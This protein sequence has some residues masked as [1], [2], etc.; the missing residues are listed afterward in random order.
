MLAVDPV[1]FE[2]VLFNMLDNAAKYAPPVRQ[3]AFK[4]GRRTLTSS[5]KSLTRAAA[6]RRRRL[7]A[8][9]RSSIEP[10]RRIRFVPALGLGLPSA[11]ALWRP[12]VARS[13]VQTGPIEQGAVFT[14]TLPIPKPTEQLDTAA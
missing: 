2:Q 3:Y 7:I 1:L 5:C 6:F 11:A 9:S 13:P 4:A 8:S 10:R 12:W 14:I